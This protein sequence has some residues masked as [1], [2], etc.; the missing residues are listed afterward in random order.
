LPDL[1]GKVFEAYSGTGERSLGICDWSDGN[2]GNDGRRPAFLARRD[3]I[4][5]ML[6]GAAAGN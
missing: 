2:D 4:Q 3:S 1:G 5:A 6:A